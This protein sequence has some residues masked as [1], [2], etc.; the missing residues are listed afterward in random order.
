MSPPLSPAVGS[1]A[2]V[3]LRCLTVSPECTSSWRKGLE[4]QD[5]REG[6][7]ESAGWPSRVGML[8]LKGALGLS[9][10]QLLKAWVALAFPLPGKE[11]QWQIGNKCPEP[12]AAA[13]EAWEGTGR[14]SGSRT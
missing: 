13:S 4:R 10:E 5:A 7:R 14:N 11:R 8:H 1:P 9:R 3:T 12:H 6:D 2:A